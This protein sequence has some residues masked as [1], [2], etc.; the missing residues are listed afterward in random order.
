M[1]FPHHMKKGPLP[2]FYRDG[3]KG[4]RAPCP[5][6]KKIGYIFLFLKLRFPLSKIWITFLLIGLTQLTAI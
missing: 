5:K 4:A 1:M 6:K 2:Q 3:P